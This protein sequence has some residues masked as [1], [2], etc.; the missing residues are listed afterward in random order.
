MLWLKKALQA[1]AEYFEKSQ[2]TGI[3]LRRSSFLKKVIRE[4]R[5]SLVAGREFSSSNHN[6]VNGSFSHISPMEESAVGLDR[7]ELATYGKLRA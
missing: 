6:F 4:K 1:A 5:I 2:I 7:F 3:R